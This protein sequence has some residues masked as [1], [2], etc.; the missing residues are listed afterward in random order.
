M[1]N[2]GP[3][4]PGE[5][6]ASPARPRGPRRRC[7]SARRPGAG[8]TEW[9]P[10]IAA[11]RRPGMTVRWVLPPRGGGSGPVGV[12]SLVEGTVEWQSR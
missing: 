12:V 11:P 2:P 7:P 9:V 8:E 4:S 6:D 5:P 10:E 3:S 1:A